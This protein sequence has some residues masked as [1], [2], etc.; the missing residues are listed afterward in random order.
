[1]EKRGKEIGGCAKRQSVIHTRDR[2]SISGPK[3]PYLYMV[4]A[5]GLKDKDISE[6]WVIAF[7]LRF[8]RVNDVLTNP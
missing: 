4:T 2:V 1:M 6:A 7:L 3:L 8:G 5:Q